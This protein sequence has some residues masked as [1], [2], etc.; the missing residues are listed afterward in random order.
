MLGPDELPSDRG[1]EIVLAG[2]VVY[3]SGD[4]PEALKRAATIFDYQDRQAAKEEARRE[5]RIVGVGIACLVEETAIGPYETGNVSVDP[6]GRVTVLT[7]ISAI[8]QGISTAITQLVADELLVPMESI[9]IKSGDTDVV[10]DGMGTYASRGGSI[11]GAAARLAARKVKEKALAI[12]ANI[13][14]V[15][16]TDLEWTDEGARISASQAPP[17]ISLGDLAARATAFNPLTPGLTAFNLEEKHHH[18]VPGIAFANGVHMAEVEIDRETGFMEVTQ[19]TAFHDCGTVINPMIIEGQVHGGVAQGLGGTLFEENRYDDKGYPIIT[20]FL[21]YL[22]PTAGDMP[23]IK[24]G[25]MESPTQLNPFGMKGAGEG[26]TVGAIG[27]ITSAVA[28]ALRPLGIELGTDGPFTP[29]NL[30]KLI[31]LAEERGR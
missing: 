4:Y 1:T 20:G 6:S 18:Q 11:G 8:G 23:R 28:D 29:P 7:G 9:V 2:K 5:G 14:G 19:Y 15:P 16:V 25:H 13:F 24:S 21:N 22:I 31:K 3:D 10:T 27:S 26:G 30:L 17:A 12:A